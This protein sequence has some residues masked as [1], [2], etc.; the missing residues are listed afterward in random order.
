[1]TTTTT[2]SLVHGEITERIIG[3]FYEVYSELGY[4]FLESVYEAS[5]ALVLRGAGFDVRRRPNVDVHFRSQCV[6]V[7]RPDL[8]VDDKVLIELK[9]TSGIDSSALSQVLNGLKATKLEVGLLF[10]FGPKPGFKRLIFTNKR[11]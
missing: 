7:F 8:I 2:Q 11:K 1:M 10:N 9:A 3:A 4:G 6:G 5:L